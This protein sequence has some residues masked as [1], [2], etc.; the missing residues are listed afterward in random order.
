MDILPE[1]QAHETTN[2]VLQNYTVQSSILQTIDFDHK[3]REIRLF[4]SRE[5]LW[6][7]QYPLAL[8]CFVLFFCIPMYSI[9][10]ILS[11]SIGMLC[12]TIHDEIY[13]GNL[14]KRSVNRKLVFFFMALCGTISVLSLCPVISILNYEAARRISDQASRARQQEPPLHGWAP[15][16]Q[17]EQPCR[18]NTL[19]AS[20]NAT[21][22]N[23]SHPIH[24]WYNHSTAQHTNITSKTRK[25]TSFSAKHARKASPDEDVF[26]TLENSIENN[27]SVLPYY[28]LQADTV[29]N[30]NDTD[31][32]VYMPVNES[33]VM[34]APQ[35][36][37][38]HPT[39]IAN[40]SI[41]VHDGN[42]SNNVNDNTNNVDKAGDTESASSNVIGTLLHNNEEEENLLHLSDNDNSTT[43]EHAYEAAAATFNEPNTFQK[44]IAWVACLSTPFLIS[45]VPESVRLP[46]VLEILQP[47]MSCFAACLLCIVL[48]VTQTSG[49]YDNNYINIIDSVLSSESEFVYIFL[50]PIFIWSSVYLII[51]IIRSK[52][53][54][55]LSCVFILFSYLRILQVAFAVEHNSVKEVLAFLG[56]VNTVYLILTII[57]CRGE[58]KAIQMGWAADREDDLYD[59]E[60]LS[61]C[62]TRNSSQMEQFQPQYTIDDVLERV[63][64]DIEH[65]E[66][67][68]HAS[69][70]SSTTTSSSSMP[71][72]SQTPPEQSLQKVVQ[73]S[74]ENSPTGRPLSIKEDEEYENH[75]SHDTNLTTFFHTANEDVQHA[76]LALD[77]SSPSI[78]SLTIASSITKITND[79]HTLQEICLVDDHTTSQGSALENETS[80][81]LALTEDSSDHAQVQKPKTNKISARSLR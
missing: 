71:V 37:S 55:V 81:L 40:V 66:R 14:W 39:V 41:D 13:R 54:S 78:D 62:E 7:I 51:K 6:Y 15:C 42:E 72:Y 61:D 16:T 64:S 58:N 53:M 30:E 69:S 70:T 25:Y 22:I 24:P 68:L 43:F 12:K 34:V 3:L 50:V 1:M 10:C 74:S 29:H 65:S 63:T 20:V 57:F 8:A 28:A 67:V 19:V 80:C 23:E 31:S 21:G 48:F 73:K 44:F 17:K 46:V 18:D 38:G 4:V 47:S 76:H 35:K 52:T 79:T 32:V 11:L 56:F 27:S 75:D 49:K 77:Q 26:D 45:T 60:Y 59:D 33:V 9:S 36:L 5:E 2:V